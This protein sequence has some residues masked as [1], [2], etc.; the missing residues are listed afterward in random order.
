VADAAALWRV[1]VERVV[2]G[3]AAIEDPAFATGLARGHPGRVA[4][5]LDTRDGAVAVRGWEATAGEG[6][7]EVLAALD[8]DAFAALVVTDIGRDGMLEGP[9]VDGLRAVLDEVPI[10]VIASGGVRSL[11][12]LHVLAALRSPSGRALAGTIVGRALYEGRF[13]VAEGV[14][15]CA[16]SG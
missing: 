3:T 8:L 11:D 10:D 1:G 2:V 16:A 4:L 12:D 5:G 7:A 13:Q 9:D 6:R 15:A 14:Q